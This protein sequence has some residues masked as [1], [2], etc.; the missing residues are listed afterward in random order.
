AFALQ[1]GD[2]HRAVLAF[3]KVQLLDPH[4]KDIQNKIADARFHLN[5][6]NLSQIPSG[7]RKSPNTVLMIGLTISGLVLPLVG[8][9][10]FSPTTR[11]RLYL[12]SGKNNRAAYIYE[13]LLS[14]S[15]GRVKLYPLLADIYLLE[16]RRDERALKVFEMVLRLNLTAKNKPEINSIVANHYLSEGRTDAHAIQIMERELNAKIQHL[17]SHTL[18]SHLRD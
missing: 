15:P 10:V 12:L 9:L 11:A 18:G 5:R 14:K 17:N 4:Y 16:N 13:R 1:N 6:T 7:E 8:I 2:W 3:E